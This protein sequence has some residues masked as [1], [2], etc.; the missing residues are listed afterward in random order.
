MKLP[1]KPSSSLGPE[2]GLRL[3]GNER[4]EKTTVA[5]IMGY[6]GT[7]RRIHSFISWLTKGQ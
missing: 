5:I 7:I 2:T 6:T 4:M 1:F 3:A